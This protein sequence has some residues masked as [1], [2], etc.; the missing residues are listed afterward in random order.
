[1]QALFATSRRLQCPLRSGATAESRSSKPDVQLR[2]DIASCACA[3]CQIAFQQQLLDSQILAIADSL[4]ESISQILAIAD[5]LEESIPQHRGQRKRSGE[6]SLGAD[7]AGAEPSPSA[8]VAG[9]A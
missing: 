5:S 8:D 3:A 9:C 7:V 2:R 4:E 6:P 1:M